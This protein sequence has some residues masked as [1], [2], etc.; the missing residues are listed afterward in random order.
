M[1]F[2][3]LHGIRKLEIDGNFID[4]LTKHN[5]M[6][7][8]GWTILIS[9]FLCAFWLV[10]EGQL[11][12]TIGRP[13]ELQQPALADIWFFAMT[14]IFS[15][16]AACT[17][18]LPWHAMVFNSSGRVISGMAAEIFGF[19]MAEMSSAVIASAVL[20]STYAPSLD[21]APKA[22]MSLVLMLGACIG[23]MGRNRWS[24]VA[25]MI[26]G[27]VYFVGVV[28]LVP[29][30]VDLLGVRTVGQLLGVALAVSGVASFRATKT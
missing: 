3:L 30:L 27:S 23:L 29:K 17:V 20:A 1:C 8:S 12:P 18:A 4:F 26:Y 19:P 28:S 7:V 13:S 16:F 14:G 2:G 22:D 25:C 21:E 24:N 15:A 11:R 5:C 10:P 9:V 6:Y